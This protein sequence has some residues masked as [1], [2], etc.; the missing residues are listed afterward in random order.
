MV[1]SFALFHNELFSAH[2]IWHQVARLYHYNE[3]VS[4]GEFPPRW[5][6]TLANGYG[7]PL[8]IFSYHLPWLLALP[9]TLSGVSIFTSMRMLFIFGLF[10]SAASMYILLFRLTKKPWASFVGSSV[11]VWAPYHFLSVYVAAAIGT[12]FMFALL[13]ILFIGVHLVL[14][15]SYRWGT[16]VIALAIA[17]SILTHLMTLAMVLP[18]AIVFFISQIIKRK[19]R[20]TKSG[21][22]IA[23]IILSLL[24]S[25]FYLIPLIKYLPSIAVSSESG[26]LSDNFQR[27]FPSLK[28]LVYS[29]WGYGPIISNA[30]DGDISMQIGIAQWLAFGLSLVVIL[31]SK[32]KIFKKLVNQKYFQVLL[33][34]GLLFILS[35]YFMLDTSLPFWNFAVKFIALDFP[36]RLLI[37]SVFSG[38]TMA[39]LAI[40]SL[41]NKKLMI[42]LGILFVLIAL[43]T[44]RNHRRV[45]MYTQ[46]A[47]EEYVGAETTTNTY[48]EYLPLT[49]GRELLTNDPT[50]A[51]ISRNRLTTQVEISEDG[52][53]SLHQFAFPGVITK[54]DGQTVV[55]GIDEKGRIKIDL[56][57]GTHDI[58]VG[59]QK[60]FLI[61]FSEFLSLM[62]LAI[63]TLLVL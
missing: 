7:Y 17:G 10:A 11:Y 25:A 60:N 37:I 22:A 30:K 46:Y 4:A 45:N 54:V 42:I 34:Y 56:T 38:S 13:P 39:T 59:F 40:S 52:T 26:G 19:D 43:Y 9:M 29:S 6:A 20:T 31:A 58:Q 23:G 32:N 14:E 44:N 28:Q 36:F 27:Y 18:F 53:I 2:D 1:A 49:A 33:G 57:K 21:V 47:L 51:E 35:I 63:I 3:V 62:A 12:V 50:E 5:V 15:R 61:R 8:F 24:I 55:S 48:H 41:K 16:V